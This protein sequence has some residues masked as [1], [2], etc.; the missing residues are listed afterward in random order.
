MCSRS[1]TECLLL[2]AKSW[3]INLA[4]TPAHHPPTPS[5]LYASPCTAPAWYTLSVG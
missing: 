1:I 4:P 5:P 3:I 2:Q